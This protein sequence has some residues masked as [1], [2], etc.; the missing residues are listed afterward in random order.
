MVEAGGVDVLPMAGREGSNG[1]F[2]IVGGDDLQAQQVKSLRDM[3]P[4]FTDTNRTGDAAFRV[5]SAGYFRA[6]GIPLVRGRLFDERDGVNAPHVALISESLARARWPNEDPIGVRIQFG[7]IDGDMRVFTVVGIVGDIRQGGLDTL[8][9]PTFYAEYRQR[10]LLSFNFTL[11]LQTTVPPSS[12]VADARRLIRDLNPDVAPQ[13]RAIDEVVGA[14]VAGR[15]FTL[16]L[17]ASFATA[18]MLVAILG[19]YGVLSYLVT[20]RSH[21]FGVRVALGAQWTDMQ[22]LVLGEG[23]RLVVL[24]WRLGLA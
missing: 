5:A 17:T 24:G 18:G 4:F 20:Q 19:V 11:V 15:R 10:P 16:A 23:G 22:R 14:S 9:R 2:L 6:M 8:P 12:L 13:F 7:N 21:E 1:T 3:M